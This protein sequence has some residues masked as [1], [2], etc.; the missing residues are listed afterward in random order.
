MNFIK[1]L[2]PDTENP[3]GGNV[4]NKSGGAW[5]QVRRQFPNHARIVAR[6]LSTSS[7]VVWN[8]V[9]SRTSILPAPI[10]RPA[11]GHGWYTAPAAFSRW[12]AS[13]VSGANTSFASTGHTGFAPAA[14]S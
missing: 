12:S 11:L 9:T 1:D 8:D 2:R 10:F 7:L 14:V 3:A 4:V 5:A 13:M 6:N